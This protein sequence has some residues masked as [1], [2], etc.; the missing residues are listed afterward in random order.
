MAKSDNVNGSVITVTNFDF[1]KLSNLIQ[2]ISENKS[3]DPEYLKYLGLELQKASKI[4]PK[5]ITPDFITMNSVAK[6]AFL[7][8]NNVMEI[9]L[10]YP[11]DADFKRGFISVLS[12]LGC[13][14]LGYKAGDVVTYKAPKG[15]QRVKIEEVVYQPEA[16]GD[17]L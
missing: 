5:L 3:I 6:V 7:E 2:T 15:E 9:R 11:Q 17:D 14:L 13:A 10:V 12:P 4:D 8:N 16:N 1:R